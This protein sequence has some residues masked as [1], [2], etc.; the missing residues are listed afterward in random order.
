MT[1]YPGYTGRFRSMAALVLPPMQCADG[2]LL[3]QEPVTLGGAL[4][5]ALVSRFI[6]QM[7]IFLRSSSQ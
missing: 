2:L 6:N 4:A 7:M 1:S 5:Q 3:F